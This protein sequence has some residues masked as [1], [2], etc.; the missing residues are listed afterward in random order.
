MK[1]IIESNI[2]APVTR[3][4]PASSMPFEQLQLGQSFFVPL[5]DKAISTV[6]TQVWRYQKKHPGTVFVTRVFDDGIRVWR[7]A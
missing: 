7:T 4:G 3:R 5:K 2:P 6:R 1:Y